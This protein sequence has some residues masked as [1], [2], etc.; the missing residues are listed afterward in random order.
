M[1]VEEI[2]LTIVDSFFRYDL[3][4]DLE[5]V[6]DSAILLVH[7]NLAEGE[8]VFVFGDLYCTVLEDSFICLE[9][10]IEIWEWYLRWPILTSLIQYPDQS[11]PWALLYVPKPVA[12]PR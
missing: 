11:A 2:L 10:K 3:C 7:G 8:A 1:F 5:F 4:F 6:E 9:K 12:L